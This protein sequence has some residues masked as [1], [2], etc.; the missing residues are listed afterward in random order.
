MPAAIA[1]RWSSRLQGQDLQAPTLLWSEAAAAIRQLEWRGEIGSDVANGALEWLEAVDI[2]PT[3]SSS[4]VA[5][6]RRLAAELGWA[7]TYDAEYIV[8]ARRLGAPLATIDV[9]LRRS[10]SAYVAPVDP[11]S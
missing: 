3:Y 1:G 6:S 9:R 2:K 10:A 8:L 5:E 7:K 4:L 11:A